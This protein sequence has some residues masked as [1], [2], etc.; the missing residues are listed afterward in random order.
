[1]CHR[2][3]DFQKKKTIFIWIDKHILYNFLFP[4]K[5]KKLKSSQQAKILK[6]LFFSSS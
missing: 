3:H 4:K 6:D 2:K 5:I 1:M